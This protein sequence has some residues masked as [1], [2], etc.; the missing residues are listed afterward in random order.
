MP[1]AI[2]SMP[3]QVSS[4][5]RRVWRHGRKRAWR[6]WRFDSRTQSWPRWSSIALRHH[7]SRPKQKY[8]LEKRCDVLAHRALGGMLQPFPRQEGRSTALSHH[9]L[10]E[11]W[12]STG[13]AR[14]RIAN[15][16]RDRSAHVRVFQGEQGNFKQYRCGGGAGAEVPRALQ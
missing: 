15:A 6:E 11:E 7:L 13:A 2:R 4:H 9:D 8:F 12:G 10:V 16:R 14:E 5:D 1:T 3:D